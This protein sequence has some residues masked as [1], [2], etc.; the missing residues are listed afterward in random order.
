M[1]N[2]FLG[3]VTEKMIDSVYL[4]TGSIEWH[5][6]MSSKSIEAIPINEDVRIYVYLQHTE[7]T[8][9]LFGFAS[10]RERLLFSDLIKV[11]GIGPKQAMKILS[12]ITVD[13]LINILDAGDADKLK[14]VPGIGK[15]TAQ[16]IFLTLK[17]KLTVESDFTGE[18]QAVGGYADLITAL[19][20]MG[21]DK[22]SA[23]D[24]ITTLAAQKKTDGQQYTESE[25]LRI[26]IVQLSTKS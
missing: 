5:I 10:K 2:S 20:E 21:F 4:D 3:R 19:A 18:S 12:S 24:C 17:G 22:R 11:N 13:Q 14:S 1:F 23:R 16:K 25:L 6:Y 8:M 7:N 15:M 26:A 9:Q